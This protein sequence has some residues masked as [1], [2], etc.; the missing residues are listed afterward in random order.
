METI[1]YSQS[2]MSCLS[3]LMKEFSPMLKPKRSLTAARTLGAIALLLI[4][5][6]HYQQ[7]RFAFYSAVPTIGPLFLANFGGATALGLFLLAPGKSRL[8]R[9]GALLEQLA[10]L[11]GVGVAA[12]GLAALLISEHTPLFGFMEHGY[13]FVIV[14]TIASEVVAIGLL[15]LFVMGARSHAHRRRAALTHKRS[16]APT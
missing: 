8:G 4:G 2:W 15:A 10:A 13:R 5:G 7:Y 12:S 3:T 9:L 16:T 11:A 14:L 1:Y 6:I